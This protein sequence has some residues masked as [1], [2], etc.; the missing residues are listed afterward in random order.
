MRLRSFY[1]FLFSLSLIGLSAGADELPRP[2][3]LETAL[4]RALDNRPE[5]KA[6]DARIEGLRALERQ[7]GFRPN[8]EIDIHSENWRFYDVEGFQPGSQVDV[9]A[10]YTQTFETG[11][12]R[13]KRVDVARHDTG[14][15]R[16]EKEAEVRSI[17][18]E[19]TQAF[20]QALQAQQLYDLR[21]QIETDFD[22][23]VIYH[24]TRVKSGSM[25]EA[26]LIKVRLEAGQLHLDTRKAALENEQ[27]KASLLQAMG[28]SALV[29][30]LILVDPGDS[31]QGVTV[32]SLD[33]MQA[34]AREKRLELKIGRADVDRARS[35]QELEQA[36]ARSDWGAIL[37]YKRT[38]G[39]NTLVAGVSL[40]LPFFDRNQGNITNSIQETHQAGYQLLVMRQRIDMDVARLA[41]IVRQRYLLFRRIESTM[42]PQAEQ[43]WRI[44]LAAYQE[45]GYDLLRLLDAR[46]S[47]SEIQLMRTQARMDYRISLVELATATGTDAVVIDPKYLQAEQDDVQD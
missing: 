6:A 18:R 25:P 15:A 42:L 11:G 19:V 22:D 16:L 21:R 40:V 45:G 5:L 37:G 44:A 30:G 17:R 34:M 9:F 31:E 20:M 28:E 27:S 47:L 29:S 32:T 10:I 8:P 26:D 3:T 33:E 7:A 12:K 43:S 36:K 41:G 39:Y 23:V 4:Q 1:L 14:L 24:E 13:E 2:L 35:R 38:D 46:R